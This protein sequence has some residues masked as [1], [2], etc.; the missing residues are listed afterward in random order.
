MIAIGFIFIYKGATTGKPGPLLVNITKIDNIPEEVEQG[1]VVVLRVNLKSNYKES[2]YR[3]NTVDCTGEI[4][5]ADS[6]E[7]V[8][9]DCYKYT[10]LRTKV[11]GEETA[12]HVTKTIRLEPGEEKEL[13]Y[14]LLIPDYGKKLDFDV[15]IYGPLQIKCQGSCIFGLECLP[16]GY[17]LNGYSP[18]I[19]INTTIK[20]G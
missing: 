2:E 13:N 5:L 9:P 19:W 8:G 7:C 15:K 14:T 3:D 6:C 10:C 18:A 4:D 20:K 1:D 12:Q 17:V 11:E 16:Y